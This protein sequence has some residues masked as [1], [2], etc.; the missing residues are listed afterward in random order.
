MVS[1]DSNGWSQFPLHASAKQ[2]YLAD[3]ASGGDDG[4]SG[5]TPE[6]PKATPSAAYAL[7]THQSG[8][9]L[10]VKKGSDFGLGFGQWKK[11]GLSADYP[12]LIG[13]YGSGARPIFQTGNAYFLFTSGGG[14]SPSTIDFL[15]ITDIEATA[16]S[17]TGNGSGDVHGVSFAIASA[18]ITIEGCRFTNF[19][20]GINFTGAH[21]GHASFRI[22]RNDCSLNFATTGAVG[23]GIYLGNAQD[24]WIVEENICD[25]NSISP[26]ETE[27]RHGIYMPEGSNGTYGIL[28]GNTSSRNAAT[29]FNLRVGGTT[30]NNLSLQNAV[31]FY[32][33]GISSPG[34]AAYPCYFRWNVALDGAN[35]EGS[36]RGHAFTFEDWLGGEC[37]HNIFAH[38]STGS[39]PAGFTLQSGTFT[40]VEVDD[41][42]LFNWEGGS[43]I[44]ATAAQL[45]G[46]TWSRIQIDLVVRT[47]FAITWNSLVDAQAMLHSSNRYYRQGGSSTPIWAG[48]SR[49]IND[50]R[51]LTS[52][53]ALSGAANSYPDPN[54]TIATYMQNVVG[55]PGGTLADFVAGARANRKGAWDARYTA[56]AVNYYIREG[57]GTVQPPSATPRRGGSILRASKARFRLDGRMGL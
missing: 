26:N 41:N 55:V 24:L 25:S 22:R 28:R 16:Q 1:L 37:K 5:L 30:E 12:M 36:G 9:Q 39:A 56:E 42:I 33:A 11:S 15:A 49:T 4:N 3:V 48:G 21:A 35:I 53:P 52:D 14:G 43:A 54:R 51:T 18:A 44:Q 7:L 23:H 32:Q 27:M 20:N 29:G 10:L 6:L 8:D 38:N 47:D 19:T 50:W 46:T 57:Y 13:T 40:N 2:V 45:A 34:V 17:Y 31:S